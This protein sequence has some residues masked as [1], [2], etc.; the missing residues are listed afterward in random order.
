M[1]QLAT[2]GGK[3]FVFSTV[4]KGIAEKNNRAVMAVRGRALVSQASKRLDDMGVDHGVYMAGHK[5]FDASK[6]IQIAS[7]DTIRSR[8]AAP[9]ATVVVLDEAHYATSKSFRNFLS[10]Y[11]DSYWLS[12]TATPWAKD[13]L[14]HL[15][16]DPKAIVYPISISELT[17]QGYLCPAKYYAPTNFDASDIAVKNGEFLDEDAIVQFEKQAVYGDVISSYKKLCGDEPTFVFCINVAHAVKMQEQFAA[18]GIA[19]PVITAKT[20]LAEREILIRDHNVIISVSTLLVGVDVPK[21]KNIIVCRP[22]K[23]KNVHVQMLGRGTRTYPDKKF[24]RVI[25]H[26]GNIARHGFL[27]DESKAILDEPKKS[28][29]ELAKIELTK[30][31]DVKVCPS[32]FMSMPAIEKVCEGCGHEFSRLVLPDTIDSEI[33]ELDLDLRSRMKLRAKYFL[34]YAWANAYKSG[35]IFVKL[36]EEFGDEACRQNW[37]VYRSAKAEYEAWQHGHAPAPCTFGSAKFGFSFAD[38]FMETDDR[39]SEDWH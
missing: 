37:Q 13:G 24:F 31:K 12:V 22:T 4:L 3:T 9:P 5:R 32:C 10:H 6:P 36:K 11:E 18:Q 7:I 28:K 34:N 17:E 27:I 26:V 35:F 19:A 15:V 1:L 25:D 20:S 38:P 21:L 23:S 2:G 29:K 16:S 39:D 33:K 8:D 30:K 14:L